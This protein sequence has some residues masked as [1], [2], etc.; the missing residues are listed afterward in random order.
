M[1][2]QIKCRCLEIQNTLCA[3]SLHHWIESFQ[4]PRTSTPLVHRRTEFEKASQPPALTAKPPH[5]K[6]TGSVEAQEEHGV[7]ALKKTVINFQSFWK[8]IIWEKKNKLK[9]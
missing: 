7:S 8:S 1:G 9:E 3:R 4:H 2:S 5:E 6:L